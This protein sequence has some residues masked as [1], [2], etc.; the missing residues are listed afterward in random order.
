[1]R[2]TL[3]NKE[4]TETIGGF[5]TKGDSTG[6]KWVYLYKLIKVFEIIYLFR[7]GHGFNQILVCFLF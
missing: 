4:L 3:K 7:F 6:G 2:E 1:M 5:K